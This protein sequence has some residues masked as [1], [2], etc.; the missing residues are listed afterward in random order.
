MKEYHNKHALQIEK[1][2]IQH[3]TYKLQPAMN[4]KYQQ[5]TNITK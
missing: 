4:K 5:Q 3:L 1:H 2:K